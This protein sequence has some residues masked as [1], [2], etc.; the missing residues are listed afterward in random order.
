MIP[1]EPDPT[2]ESR[3]TVNSTGQG[4]EYYRRIAIFVLGGLLTLTGGGLLLLD[5]A[6]GNGWLEFSLVSRNPFWYEFT[7]ANL[8]LGLV[9]IVLGMAWNQLT[10]FPRWMLI[11]VP[12]LTVLFIARPQSLLWTLFRVGFAMR[13][14]VPAFI[15]AIPFLIGAAPVIGLLWVLRQAF[16]GKPKKRRKNVSRKRKTTSATR[17][18]KSATRENEV[19]ISDSDDDS[20]T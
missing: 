19:P 1:A 15:S 3:S 10:R 5:W 12:L 16:Y 2:A 20:E 11:V 9:M 13:S 7:A 14:M 4:I 17:S 18:T 6:N 8:R